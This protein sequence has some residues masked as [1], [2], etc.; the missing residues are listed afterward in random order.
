MA[1]YLLTPEQVAEQ[2][3]IEVK[4]VSRLPIARVRIGTKLLRYR[5]EDI[6]RYVQER[7]EAP[8]AQSPRPVRRRRNRTVEVRGVHVGLI[9]REALNKIPNFS[10]L[11]LDKIELH[12]AEEKRRITRLK[13]LAERIAKKKKDK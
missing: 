11:P 1:T 7:L 9:S 6:D 13:W 2:L 12:S 8:E 5:Q 4:K 10:K 3:S